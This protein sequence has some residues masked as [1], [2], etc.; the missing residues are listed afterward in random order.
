MHSV[1]LNWSLAISW[2]QFVYLE[3]TR[4]DCQFYLFLCIFSCLSIC[5]WITFSLSELQQ[6][7]MVRVSFQELVTH[8]QRNT[9]GESFPDLPTTLVY[10]FK[11]A[12][13]SLQQRNHSQ[14]S[15]YKHDTRLTVHPIKIRFEERLS[16]IVHRMFCKHHS[17]VGCLPSELTW[18]S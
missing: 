10:A 11:D 7:F 15:Q 12:E 5:K 6:Q 3:L 4:E 8:Y 16:A 1:T 2:H 13:R 14:Q 18:P 9:L 17:F